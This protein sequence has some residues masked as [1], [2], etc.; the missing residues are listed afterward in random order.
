MAPTWVWICHGLPFAISL[1]AAGVSGTASP[2]PAQRR[3]AS[4]SITA[5]SACHMHETVQ[6]CMVG[7]TEYRILATGTATS[8]LPSSYTDCHA[9]ATETWCM[10]PNGGEVQ[11]VAADAAGD[12][13][14]ATPAPTATSSRITAVTDCHM[15]ETEVYCFADA[16]EY[17]VDTTVTATS[18]LPP[19][20]TSCHSHGPDTFCVSPSGDDVQIQ[21]ASEEDEGNA[22]EP[23]GENCHFHAGVEHCVG[24]GGEE[25][26]RSCGRRERDYNVPLRIGLLFV[27]LVTSAIGVFAPMILS[28]FI[29]SRINATALMV[30]RQFGTGVILSTSLVHLYTH[31]ELMFGNECIGALQYEAVT[32]SIVMA[33]LFISFLIEYLGYR[34][35]KWQARKK[36]A[37]GAETSPGKAAERLETVSLY[38]MEAGIIFHSIIIGVTLVVA[39]D[40]FFLTLF[41]VILFHQMFEGLA[42]GSRIADLGTRPISGMLAQGHHGHS[43]GLHH[44]APSLTDSQEKTDTHGSA[45]A[46]PPALEGSTYFHVPLAKK[47]ALG[48]AFA[49]VTPV[50]MAI[51]IGVLNQFNGNDPQTVVAIGVLDA[52]SAGIL[53]WVGVVEMWAADWA[54]G[55]A[56]SDAGLGDTLL[57]LTGLVAGMVVMSVLGKW[58]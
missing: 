29:T 32:A 33:G 17:R 11:V 48:A 41:A 8:D 6:Y 47:L 25:G 52:F 1:A 9:H 49:L 36:K 50:G 5:V 57:G 58:A 10:N 40:S 26:P 4:P 19:Q 28:K 54:F 20:Y 42:L 23:A 38:V 22:N 53:L 55:G 51:G 31:A 46:N 7:P 45:A 43:H 18:D 21:L 56:L 37:E 14:A 27:I 34:L 13:P 16:T 44:G 35:V 15:H 24:A 2:S 30:V 3:Q 12:G 39:G